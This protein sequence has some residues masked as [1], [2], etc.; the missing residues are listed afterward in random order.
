MAPPNKA[1]GD[2]L[3]PEE[4]AEVVVTRLERFIRDHRTLSRGVSFR[5]WQDL[6]RREIVDLLREM[7]SRHQDDHRFL[8]R[9]LMILGAGLATVGLWGTALAVHAAPD[10]V[11]VGILTLLGGLSV[12]W[13]L[14]ALG[15]RSPLRRFRRDLTRDRM[16]RVH[17]LNR[18]VRE[19][20][21][22]LKK[23]RKA[24]E[25]DLDETPGA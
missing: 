10:R 20:E 5:Q 22:Q 11:F 9:T 18:K 24:L 6:A 21:D 19:L 13:C 7:E 17:G 12:L 25:R 15:L 4:K 23:R 8:D 14:G 1:A 2:D 16:T 3:S